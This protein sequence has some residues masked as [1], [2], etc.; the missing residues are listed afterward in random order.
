MKASRR[1]A[2]KGVNPTQHLQV[3]RVTTSTTTRRTGTRGGR[4]DGRMK[5]RPTHSNARLHPC[6]WTRRREHRS[7]AV[8]RWRNA[9]SAIGGWVMSPTQRVPALGSGDRGRRSPR[10]GRASVRRAPGASAAGKT[11]VR[12]YARP[13][14]RAAAAIGAPRP[15]GPDGT[16]TVAH[17]IREQPFAEVVRAVPRHATSPGA[18]H[19]G[20]IHS[21]L[22]STTSNQSAE[23]STRTPLKSNRH[24]HVRE[25]VLICDATLTRR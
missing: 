22:F 19:S 3:L 8:A 17:T 14:P 2:T 24:D 16:R 1:Y 6:P 7:I 20:R 25:P 21:T 18:A 9:P 10:A 23:R 11:V 15:G 13:S 4:F 5:V 12:R